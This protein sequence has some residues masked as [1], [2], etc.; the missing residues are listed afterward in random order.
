MNLIQ[1]CQSLLTGLKK[2][3]NRPAR[4]SRNTPRRL[5]VE[6]LES[7][8]LMAVGP[9]VAGAGL[10]EVPLVRVF[11][12]T[13]LAQQMQI[14]AFEAAFRGGVR[15]ATGDINGD[16]TLD[17]IAAAGKGGGPHVRVFSG[18]NGQK[19]AGAVGDFFAF[20]KAFKGGIYV[21]SGDID[22]DGRDD[23]VVAAGRGG[24]PHVRVFSG[25]TGGKIRD[26]FAYDDD[27]RG[28]V[29]IAVG[30]VNEDARD[31]IITGAA[32]GGGPHVK[33]FS[34]LNNAKL[35]DF[36]AY[37][38]DFTGG[39]NV[40][41]GD[42]NDDGNVDIITGAGHGGRPHVRAFSGD[43]GARLFQFFA[44]DRDFTGGILVGSA[45]LNGD[46]RSD[47]ITGA[48]A[49]GGPDVGVYS[50]VDGGRLVGFFPYDEDATGGVY[51]AGIDATTPQTLKRRE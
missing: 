34:G 46:G 38:T 18:V 3:R 44:Y 42:V 28:G 9:L 19:L 49:N 33:V 32:S 36:F 24:G 5:A 37:D 7:R 14:Q 17:I 27:F 4:P 13:T 45:D 50:G 51:V 8:Q 22:G 39:V 16:G 10:R 41:A 12:P 11:D 15:V 6:S 43:T 2:S 1:S 26:F 48:D 47:V 30:D 40:A 25:M 29:T 23:I 20:E 21:A 35:R 31:D